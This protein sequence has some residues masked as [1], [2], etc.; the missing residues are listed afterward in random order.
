LPHGILAVLEAPRGRVDDLA[1]GL[2]LR[3]HLR[4]LVADHLEAAD[5]PPERAPLLGVLERAVEHVLGARDRSGRA[6]QALSLELPHDV[7]EALAWLSED[8]GLGDVHVLEPLI[9]YSSPSLTAR[10]L[11]PATSEPASGSVMPMQRIALPWIAGTSHSCFCSSVPNLRIGGIAMSVW[12]AIPIPRPP[13][14]AW[15]S[16]SA[17][18]RVV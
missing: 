18:T 15:T 10:V 1:R 7:V 5:R 16:S 6:D 13:L 8:R 12:T 2:D 11:I 3:R 17:S 9:T 4:E 14:C